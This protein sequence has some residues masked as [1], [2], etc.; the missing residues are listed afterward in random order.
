VAVWKSLVQTGL[1]G[2]GLG[3]VVFWLWVCEVGAWKLQQDWT[4]RK[5]RERGKNWKP[6]GIGRFP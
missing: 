2:D 1:D 6:D 5:V 3:E 4:G